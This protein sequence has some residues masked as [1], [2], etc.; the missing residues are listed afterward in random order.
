MITARRIRGIFPLV[1]QGVLV[2]ETTVSF[3]KEDFRLVGFELLFNNILRE[4]EE[5]S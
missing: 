4:E 2:G 1:R 5:E 3:E